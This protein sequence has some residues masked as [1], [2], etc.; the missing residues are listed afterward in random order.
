MQAAGT[1]SAQQQ[2][3]TLLDQLLQLQGS[4]AATGAPQAS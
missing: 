3:T 4:A 1:A 2:L